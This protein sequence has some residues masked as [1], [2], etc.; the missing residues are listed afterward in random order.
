MNLTELV[1]LADSKIFEF[2]EVKTLIGDE[3]KELKLEY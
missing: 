2:Y 3:V 1:S